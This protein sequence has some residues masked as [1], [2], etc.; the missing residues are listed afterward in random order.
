MKRFLRSLL[1]KYILIIFISLFLIQAAYIIIIVVFFTFIDNTESEELK[2][3]FSQIEENWHKEASQIENVSDETI[4][5]LFSNWHFDYSQASMFWID[6]DGLLQVKINT[7]KNLPDKWGSSYTAEFLKSHYDSDPFTTIAFVGKNKSD[8]FIVFQ[9]PRD[10]MDLSEQSITERYGWAIIMLTI[11]IVFLFLFLFFYFFR[12]IRKRLVQ[13]REAM[14][15]RDTDGLP[16][17]IEERKLDEIGELKKSF[18]QMVKELR[19]SKKR[20]E[21][22]EQLRKELIANLS[23]DL[24]TPLTK[25]NAQAFT[26]EKMELPTKA[27]HSIQLVE[28]SINDIDKLIDNLMSYT[29]LIA[30]KYQ[31]DIKEVDIIRHVRQCLATWFPVFEKEG[32]EVNIDMEPFQQKMWEIDPLWFSRIIDNLLQNVLRHAQDGKYLSIQTRSTENYDAFIITD[33]G[34]GMQ[35]NTSEKGEGIGLSIVDMMIKGMEL[36][37]QIDSTKHGTTISLIRR[38]NKDDSFF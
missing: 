32:F 6:E 37:W 25:I 27:Q 7:Q 12:N 30:S 3:G 26:L 9:L 35:E 29:L 2:K 18:N 33:K 20:E 17:M 21:E 31:K 16:I 13:L 14:E 22:E 24:R 15:F 38:K 11:G 8:G 10:E 1:A 34:K 28:K 4:N 23:H 36:D 5:H 19:K